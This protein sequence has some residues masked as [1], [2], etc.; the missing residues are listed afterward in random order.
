VGLDALLDRAASGKTE[1][2]G[3]G[4]QHLDELTSSGNEPDEF[5]LGFVGKRTRLWPDP[6]GEKG[7]NPGVDRVGLGQFAGG[8]SEVPDCRGLTTA[9][10]SPSLASA[11][12]AA[13]S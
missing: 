9:T 10:G 6:L 12:A 1:P 13:L 3:F 4:A 2:V 8:S 11:P 5:L 7:E